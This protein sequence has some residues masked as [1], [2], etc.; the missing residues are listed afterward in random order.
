M[1]RFYRL[2]DLVLRVFQ[3][4]PENPFVGFAFPKLY[5]WTGLVSCSFQSY[6]FTSNFDRFSDALCASALNCHYVFILS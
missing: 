5:D 6:D 4:A 1:T 3:E 2:D